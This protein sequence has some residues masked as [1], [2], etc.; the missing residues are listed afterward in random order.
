M[1][2]NSPGDPGSGGGSK[3]GL[4]DPQYEHD[5][6]GVG[7]VAHIK[8]KKSH[9][10]V[11]NALIMLEQMDHRGACGCEPNTGDGAGI[12]TGLPHEF[13]V[14][15]AMRDAGIALPEAGEYG[16]GIVFFPADSEERAV[17][18]R[19]MAKIVAEQGLNA[20]GVADGADGECDAGDGRAAD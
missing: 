1:R 19:E 12:L 11:R 18:E 10:I 20:F 17:C 8:G 13:L 6:C 2:S 5:S 7:F 3:W 9:A 14:K 16:A 15:V 4:Y